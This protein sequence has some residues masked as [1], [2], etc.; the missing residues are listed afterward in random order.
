MQLQEI[1]PKL[2]L[3]LGALYPVFSADGIYHHTFA[4]LSGGLHHP[5]DGRIIYRTYNSKQLGFSAKRYACA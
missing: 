2:A 1:D 5:D 3:F 4:V